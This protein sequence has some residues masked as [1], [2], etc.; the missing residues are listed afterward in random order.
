MAERKQYSSKAM[1]RYFTDPEFRRSIL[2]AGSGWIR[3]NKRIA[4]ALLVLLIGFSGWYGYHIID[5]LPSLEQLENPSLEISTKIYSADGEVLDQFS[6]KNRTP[7][8]LDQLPPGLIEA[9]IATEDKQF[10]EHWGVNA[11]RFIRQMAI[12]LVTFR[13]AGASTI[14]QQLARNLYKL[15]GTEESLFDK[16]TRKIREFI[17]SV[18]IERNFTKKEILQLYL[19]ESYFG[20]AAYGIES[21]AQVY[22]KKRAKE[23]VPAEYTLLI[24]MLK[25]PT[26]YD[27]IQHLDRA[28]VRRDIVINQMLNDDVISDE[29]ALQIR[30][31]TLSFHLPD[32]ELRQ[33][34][35]PH[36]VEWIRQQLVQKSRTYGFNVLRDGLKVYTTLDAR[37]QRHAN[38]AVEEHMKEFQAKWDTLWNW[39][40][41]PEILAGNVEKYITET[42]AYKRAKTP[43]ARDSIAAALRA[44]ST[45][46]DSVR[47]LARTIEVGF[48]VINPHDGHIL[49]MVGGANFRQF[50]Y[51]LNHVTQIRRQPGSAF[52]PFVYTVAVDNGYSVATELM[53]QPVTIPM[54]DGTRWTP[55]NY[56]G[57]FGGYY[58]L[59]EGLKKSINLIAV[60]TILT[61]A[62]P[63]QVVEYAKRMGIRS[64]IRPY[65]SI[66]L[67]SVEVSPLELTT[68]YGVFANEGVLVEPIAIL[69][70]EDKDGNVIEQNFP[71]KREALN[72]ETA[73]IMTDLLEGVVNEGTARRV[74][75][76][77]HYPAAGKTGTTN[78]YGDAWF[79][80]FTPQLSAGVWVGFDDNRIKFGYAEGQG[81]R[82][83]APIWARFMK[84]T[85]EDPDIGMKLEYFQ[86]PDGVVT[87]TIC[88]ET[89]KKAREWCPNKVEEI[90]NAKY[91]LSLCDK[92]TSI[93]WNEEQQTP[94]KIHW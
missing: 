39:N 31:D 33:G 14:T 60:R 12:N 92:H 68:A 58:T 59:R 1:E 70:I 48:V 61:L 63:E 50:K 52:K 16:I 46:V 53:N 23:L 54:P 67:G 3:R 20:R 65:P 84:Y 19:N 36:F 22:F 88:V 32:P 30:S 81:G 18:Q 80:G 2:N 28:L 27:P 40:A 4:A 94:S 78:D 85:Y 51:G 24:G 83:A 64:K 79:V 21:A 38:R 41:Y 66:A 73:Y 75:G 56:D 42:E 13:Q 34:I 5:G 49:A 86:R 44:D 9:L 11:P 37:M 47:V 82:A 15:K 93:H 89:K 8:T 76:Y 90:F 25:G 69:R 71:E 6:V 35:A 7:V 91:P 57:D 62:P 74:R 17:T 55:S 10:Y 77:Y 43:E 45:F 87:D 26:Y 29:D 72:R